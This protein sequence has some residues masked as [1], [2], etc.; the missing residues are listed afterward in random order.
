MKEINQ[1]I[2]ITKNIDIL[3]SILKYGFY[4]SYAKEKFGNKN[5]LIPMI[6]FSNILFRDIGDDEVVDYGNYGVVFDRDDVIE[7]FDL[8]PVF[9][10]KNVSELNDIFSDNL[11]TV[12]LQNKWDTKFKN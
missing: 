5:I 6:S 4:T 7:K 11:H 8:N 10:V 2:H 12:C 3:K 1:I 9:Y